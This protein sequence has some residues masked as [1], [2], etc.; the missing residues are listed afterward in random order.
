MQ[1]KSELRKT[2]KAV[3]QNI[4]HRSLADLQITEHLFASAAYLEAASVFCYVSAGTEVGTKDVLLDALAS[5]KKVAVPYCTEQPG[6]MQ[7]YYIDSLADLLPGKYGILAPDPHSCAPA[8]PDAGTLL[9]VPG[10]AFDRRGYRLGYGQGYYDRYLKNFHGI[11]I[12]LCYNECIADKMAHDEHDEC[13]DYL[14]CQDFI[15]KT[16]QQK[17]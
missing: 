15:M 6:I 14:A 16:E 17:I 12:G 11:S 5:G 13:V 8:E 4:A 9:V 3:R 10:L 7:F 1:I 2:Y